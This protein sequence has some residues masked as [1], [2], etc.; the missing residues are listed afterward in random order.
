MNLILSM[1]QVDIYYI[2]PVI[3]AK[4]DGNV[5]LESN[6]H[7]K[8]DNMFQFEKVNIADDYY[9]ENVILW[10]SICQNSI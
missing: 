9:E 3:E 8:K 6:T 1:M 2:I 7:E 10:L 5:E 4:P